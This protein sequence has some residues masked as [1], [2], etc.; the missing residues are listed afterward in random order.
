[1]LYG[2]ARRNSGALMAGGLLIGLVAPARVVAWSAHG[3]DLTLQP[4]IIEVITFL[5]LFAAARQLR[6]N[7][8]GVES[9][10]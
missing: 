10:S 7:G 8:A 4:I 5:S 9:S 2:V 3:A 6:A 1:M